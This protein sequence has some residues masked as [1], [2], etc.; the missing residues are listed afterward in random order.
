MHTHINEPTNKE[1]VFRCKTCGCYTFIT[2]QAIIPSQLISYE[3]FNFQTPQ[4]SSSLTI[5]YL[6]P[7]HIKY[8]S[9]RRNGIRTIRY[10]VNAL[11]YSNTV[12]YKAILYMDTIFL[13]SEM[14]L[15]LIDNVST[16]C[17]L[18]SLQ[19]NECC[20]TISL[21][22][23]FTLVRLIPHYN[24][25]EIECLKSLQYDL[26]GYTTFDFINWA[27]AQGVI[28]D[29]EYPYDIN[30]LYKQCIVCMNNFIED[31]RALD[32]NPFVLAMTIIKY[33]C[34]KNQAFHSEIVEHIYNINYRS[35]N[36]AQCY[37]ILYYVTNAKKDN[38]KSKSR[39]VY[40]KYSSSKI[41]SST[42]TVASMDSFS[43]F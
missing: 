32:F 43:Q 39:Y 16:I 7:N 33:I 27:F 40:T 34:E 5:D 30:A 15:S 12:L 35:N 36:Y 31:D 10:L 17:V 37:C 25:L 24:E 38:K 18:L 9:K 8:L 6:K 41:Y 11:H 14:S 22:D 26:G 4:I 13:N 29:T 42:S 28:F 3:I 20:S 21:E 19:F 23:L 2:T 1:N